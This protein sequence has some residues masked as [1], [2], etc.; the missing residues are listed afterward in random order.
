MATKQK[1]AAA[2]RAMQNLEI[3]E[4]KVKPVLKKLL[5]LYDKNWELIE[6]E[7]YRA[8]ADAIFESNDF[9]E[10]EEQKKNKKVN[11]EEMEDEEASMND[12]A[13]RPLKRL[14]LRG[15]ESQH[16]DC[17]TNDSPSSAAS[18][19]KKLRIEK[20]T[21]LQSFPAQQP[22]NKAV[23]SDGNVRIEA[24]LGPMRDASSDRGKQPASPQVS[25]GGRRHISERGSPSKQPS[26]EPG[27]SLLPSNQTPHAYALIIPKDEPVDEVPEYEVPIAVIPPEPSSLRDSSMKNGTTRKQAGH[28]PVASSQHRDRVRNEDIRP[29]SNKEVASNVVIASSAKGEVKLSLSCNSAI[30]GPDFRMANQEQLL[31]MMEDKCLR[32]YKITDPN[33]SIAKMLRD[34]CDC[35]LEFS[36]DSN[37]D[38]KE[39]SMTRSG[40]DVLKESEA[41]D[42]P[43]VEGNKEL[44]ILSHSSNG[45]VHVNSFS[46][47][48]SPRS[49]FS[50]TNQS[51]LDDGVLL[52]KMD[53]S[54]DFSQSDGKKQLEDPVSPNSRSL[55][56][57]PHHQ[58]TADDAR[59]F[60]DVNDLTKGNENVQI[61]WVNETTDDFPPSFNY[62]PQNLVFQDAHVNIS[63]SRI[64][65]A[66]CCSCVGSCVYSTHCACTDKAGGELA[67]T[68]QGLMKEETLEEC[69]AIS[70]NPQ[71]HYFYC[72]DCPLERSKNDGC[73]E[74]CKGHLKR[75]FIKECWSKC[76]CGKQCGNRVIQRGITY[77]L[78]VFFTS[79][80]KG[81]GLRTLEDL[82]KGAFVCEFAG[83]I[84]TIGEL[85]ERNMKCTENGK[86]M[87]PILLDADWD[88][89]FVKDEEALCLDAASF[90]NIARFIN[91]RCFDANLV[92]IPIQIE[93]PDRYYYHFALF[94]SRNIAAQEELTWF[95]MAI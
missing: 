26:V 15:Q 55:V 27:K 32:S 8:L 48:V 58:L 46:A 83:E 94:T 78:Q 69:I 93:C 29:S 2:Y 57:V 35:M 28:V 49:P 17:V 88:S 38:S 80:E 53:K 65:T 21:T 95:F 74:P 90:G 76:G 36:T 45:S 34:I 20:A 51:S 70:H 11:E 13:A 54:H 81:W 7:N 92:E 18:P 79:E 12:E 62:I 16:G 6:E 66:D 5:K 1:V 37:G 86:S 71:Q 63:L 47:L 9:E 25:L 87:Y 10:P 52:S 75:K 77:N 72:K 40:V 84:L 61:S 14:R 43:I 73:L 3:P 82:P 4:A 67:Y 19:L 68:A 50:P 91:H 42:T 31:K 41:H 89:G 39:G 56:I 59:S 85:H 23:S 64:G 60:H 44:D 30:A 33:F 24:R 22:Q